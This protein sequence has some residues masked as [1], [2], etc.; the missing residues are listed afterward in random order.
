MDFAKI[1][2][3]SQPSMLCRCQ[4]ALHSRGGSRCRRR[5]DG[6]DP[7]SVM[8]SEESILFQME[9]NRLASHAVQQDHNNV[10]ESLSHPFIRTGQSL[11]TVFCAESF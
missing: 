3:P 7:A 2:A 9:V 8:A 11:M 4:T 5:K 1:Q 6:G 10:P